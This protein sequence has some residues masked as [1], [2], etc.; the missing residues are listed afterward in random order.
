MN[1][2][3]TP[4]PVLTERRRQDPHVAHAKHEL[5]ASIFQGTGYLRVKI[6][7]RAVLIKDHGRGWGYERIITVDVRQCYKPQDIDA[8]MPGS[9]RHYIDGEKCIFIAV[10]GGV[11]IQAGV[12]E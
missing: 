6:L 4:G 12:G 8:K 11:S 7:S 1:V 10:G 3:A 5:H 9:E 2:E